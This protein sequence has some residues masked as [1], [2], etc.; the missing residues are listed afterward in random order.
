MT[1]KAN[2]VQRRWSGECLDI[3]KAAAAWLLMNEH[4][5]YDI[6]IDDYCCTLLSLAYVD[7]LERP[8][9]HLRETA[10]R[11]STRFSDLNH[12]LPEEGQPRFCASGKGG[13]YAGSGRSPEF[14]SQIHP[15][16]FDNF[17]V[18]K[19]GHGVTIRSAR[20]CAKRITKSSSQMVAAATQRG[21]HARSRA[22]PG[23]SICGGI[24]GNLGSW[25]KSRPRPG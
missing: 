13:A 11:C 16:A 17:M 14:N 24:D 18:R 5:V 3:T 9:R 20:S 10:R 1:V 8:A 2:Y 6:D 25:L 19:R 4:G 23:K 21:M 7:E 12:A 15:V 22:W